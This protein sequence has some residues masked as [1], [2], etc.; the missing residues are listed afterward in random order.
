MHYRINTPQI[1]FESIDDE[2]IIIDFE[3]GTYYSVRDG[4]NQIW[5][6]L[7]EGKSV[8]QIVD[9]TLSRYNGNQSEI[10]SL[11]RQFISN[12]AQEGLIVEA[13]AR[14]LHPQEPTT[15]GSTPFIMPILERYTDMQDLL[16][17]DPIHEVDPQGWPLR[18]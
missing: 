6:W 10:E 18:R 2:T 16:L 7:N 3:S 4:A 14:E 9:Q 12:L 8:D 1:V 5:K 15:E 11:A 17:L 13:E